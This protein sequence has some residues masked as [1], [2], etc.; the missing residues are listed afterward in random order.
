MFTFKRSKSTSNGLSGARGDSACTLNHDEKDNCR[1]STGCDS[2]VFI[3]WDHVEKDPFDLCSTSS[4]DVEDDPKSNENE[5]IH[6]DGDAD[7]LGWGEGSSSSSSEIKSAELVVTELSIRGGLSTS[8]RM[9]LGEDKSEIGSIYISSSEPTPCD[10]SLNENASAVTSVNEIP[11]DGLDEKELPKSPL[12]KPSRRPMTSP[13]KSLLRR[14]SGDSPL[15]RACNLRRSLTTCSNQSSRFR[16]LSDDSESTS[17]STNRMT[18]PSI[19]NLLSASFRNICA[20]NWEFLALDSDIRSKSTETVGPPLK[21]YNQNEAE[22]CPRLQ[23]LKEQSIGELH[24]ELVRIQVQ[25]KS[26]L[27]KSWGEAERIRK[28]NEALDERILQLKAKIELT[29]AESAAASN[30]S[31]RDSVS[32]GSCNLSAACSLSNNSDANRGTH[33]DIQRERKKPVARRKSFMAELSSSFRLNSFEIDMT[34]DES[35]RTESDNDRTEAVSKIHMDV[36]SDP[37]NLSVLHSDNTISNECSIFQSEALQLKMEDLNEQLSIQQCFI[38]NIIADLEKQDNEIKAFHIKLERVESGEQV[39]KL[40]ELESSA[41][42]DLADFN[43]CFRGI[44]GKLETIESIA[45]EIKLSLDKSTSAMSFE[46]IQLGQDQMRQTKERL[47]GNDP[48]F[49]DTRVLDILNDAP[50]FHHYEE[51]NA[52]IVGNIFRI[53]FMEADLW[54]HLVKIRLLMEQIGDD[55]GTQTTE[56]S[57]AS[58]RRTLERDFVDTIIPHIQLAH[59]VKNNL[60]A[61]LRENIKIFRWWNHLI[62]VMECFK[63][64]HD[65]IPC[66]DFIL[67]EPSLSL[68]KEVCV[69]RRI[70]EVMTNHLSGIESDI[71]QECDKFRSKV[72]RSGYLLSNSVKEL[73]LEDSK[74]HVKDRTVYQSNNLQNDTYTSNILERRGV[75]AEKC[76]VLKHY[77]DQLER[78]HACA[79]E[80]LS[81]QLQVLDKV[82]NKLEIFTNTMAKQDQLL[83]SLRDEQ[84]I[85]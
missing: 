51:C 75:L 67:G 49:Y 63:T 48:Q 33:S 61:G 37:D 20:E 71:E 31:L 26:N 56:S 82:Q 85:G 32:L 14:L 11:A 52:K 10:E 78:F 3:A 54:N 73:S 27:E 13:P 58:E 34:L 24:N 23:Q 30:T 28:T 45:S 53:N 70:L 19:S 9:R 84:E 41:A 79:N 80:E 68:N 55:E 74:Q 22:E 15:P 72:E 38:D 7:F 21:K 66:V 5:A 81:A 60:L 76:K 57:L 8:S 69:L 17:R 39:K 42:A 25:S 47:C 1:A 18:K 46:N 4:E 62:D 6:Y 83:A 77:A 40:R 2:D 36:I 43:H 12:H 35:R 65:V 59:T 44:D 29:K 64:Y 16:R 50:S